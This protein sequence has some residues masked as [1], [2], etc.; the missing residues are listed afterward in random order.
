MKPNLV[1]LNITVILGGAFAVIF[2]LMNSGMTVAADGG[3]VRDGS[4]ILGS[5]LKQAKSASEYDYAKDVRPLLE[6]YCF[7]CHGD[8]TD[9]GAL[10]LDEWESDE[11]M[12]LDR[13]TWKEVMHH[14]E[15]KVMPPAKKKNQPTDAERKIIA[16]W[17]DQE[18][19]YVDCSNPDPGR[20]TIRRLNRQEYNNTIRDLVGVNFQP[21]ADFPPDDSG[22]GFDNIG[23]VLSISPVLLEKYLA[24][25]EKIMDEAIL[26]KK[27][28]PMKRR[29]AA[30]ELR[31]GG[32]GGS[33]RVLAT[34]GQVGVSHKVR[35]SGTYTVRVRA[36]AHQAG[37]EA[38]KM[39]LM[40]GSRRLKT[41]D[42]KN[43][44]ESGQDF[45]QKV[46]LEPGELQLAAEFVNDFYDPSAKDTN[47]RDRNLLVE[48]I[49]IIGPDEYKEPQ[50]PQFH[51]AWLP[52]DPSKIDRGA[53]A[54]KIL[55]KFSSSAFRRPV[56]EDEVGRLLELAKLGALGGGDYA[57]ERGLKLAMVGVLVSPNFL[58]RNELQP[59]PNNPAAVY[60][61]D[62]FALASRLSYFLWSSMPDDELVNQ[63]RSNTLRKN[64]DA[65]VKRMLADPKA[66]ALT[67]DFAGQW[68]QL[69]DLALVN[70]DRKRFK[71][72]NVEL[73][74]SM[75][76]E[77]ELFFAD[78]V[79]SDRN[80]LEFLR[81][82]YT[83][84]NELLAKHYG[85]DGVSGKEFQK[86]SLKGSQRGGVL[87]HASILTLTSNPTRTSPVKR[88][89]WIL[90]NILGTPPPDPPA[91]IPP[92]DGKSELSGTIRQKLEQ[93]R[94]DPN[95]A[96]CHAL[97]DPIGLA[98]ENF[99]AIGRWRTEDNGQPIVASGVLDSGEEIT[100]AESLRQVLVEK[101][102]QQFTRALSE[103]MLTYA[104]GRGLEYYDRC[105]VDKI[106]DEVGKGGNRFSSLVLA[107][108]RSVPF[109]MRRGDGERG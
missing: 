24:A 71:S 86:V 85:L 14:V 43:T 79:R 77:T 48:W 52:E 50:L 65:Q 106:V 96:A 47:R 26:T 75:R 29:Y 41:F 34:N 68:L 20:V 94:E 40:A 81:A 4:R 12:M 103:V 62:E 90:D 67:E 105:A 97:M 73:R 59:D 51:Q 99:D 74:D 98:F 10:V 19:F 101:Q 42:V 31:G 60:Q 5:V 16:T 108:T 89:K 76:K 6:N 91:N 100:G 78:M 49:E 2:V 25:A 7:D 107:I 9:K 109:Q 69:R 92:L 72:F 64:L 56:R 37:Q 70:P 32:D 39:T 3:G 93:H 17:I 58:F 80:I 55:E 15:A 63:A 21:A 87:T 66:W 61:I 35:S 104:L 33:H 36:G 1:L 38:A 23:D 46:Q 44:P 30:R 22:Y 102:S 8:G 53:A 95:C 18:V 54:R 11:E 88:G 13:R 45:E 84:A 82:D 57:F 83:F 27:P 28:A